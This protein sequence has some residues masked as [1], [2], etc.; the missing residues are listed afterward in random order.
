MGRDEKDTVYCRI[1]M[2]LAQGQELMKLVMELRASGAHAELKA[3]FS[4]MIDE[5]QTS[6]DFVQEMLRG[7]EAINKPFRLPDQKP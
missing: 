3:V 1:Q 2:P 6:V 4:E 7:L 5:L